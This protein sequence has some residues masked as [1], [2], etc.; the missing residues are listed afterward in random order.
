MYNDPQINIK[1][2]FE[3]IGGIENMIISDKDKALMSFEEYKR[4][5]SDAEK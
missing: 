4:K 5:M 2:P 3:K 1:W